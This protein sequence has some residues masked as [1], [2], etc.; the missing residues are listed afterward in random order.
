MGNE[1]NR[2]FSKEKIQMARKK[3]KKHTKKTTKKYSPSLAIKKMQIKTTLICH[4]TPVRIATIKNTNNNKCWQG[5][6]EKG[7]LI[8]CW[9]ECKLV[10]PLGKT[11]WRLLIKLK[12]SLPYDPAIPFLGIYLKECESGYNKSTCT[13]MFT[14]ALFIIDKIRKQPKCPATDEWIK[15]VIFIYN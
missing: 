14:V 9:W 15:N 2:S 7:T 1:L 4:L 12:I 8:H 11:L 3:K 6:T 13:P 10:Q 5:C